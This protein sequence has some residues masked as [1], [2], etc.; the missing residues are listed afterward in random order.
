MTLWQ[1]RNLATDS[2]RNQF[3]DIPPPNLATY[4]SWTLSP[5]TKMR[6]INSDKLNALARDLGKPGHD[7]KFMAVEQALG[8]ELAEER[9]AGR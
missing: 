6:K 7:L 5:G 9:R 3:S 2:N 8:G 1:D 4:A